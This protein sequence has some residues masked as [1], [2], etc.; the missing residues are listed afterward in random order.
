MTG[1]EWVFPLRI[2]DLMMGWSTFPIRKEAKKL[3]KAALSSLLW[4]VWKERNRVTFDNLNF[5][6]DRIKHSLISFITT[7]AG[8]LNVGE[9]PLVNLLMCVL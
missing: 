5:S 2:K 6:S 3:W 7:W 8:H 4:A 1:M 9:Y